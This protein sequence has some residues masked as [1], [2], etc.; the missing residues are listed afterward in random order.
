M[1]DYIIKRLENGNCKQ[2]GYGEKKMRIKLTIDVD[3]G[4][5]G[6]NEDEVK[7]NIVQFSK[8]LIIIG[9]EELDIALTLKEVEYYD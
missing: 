1:K 3:S 2:I 7:D 9:A 4:E 6:L 5:S 8:D